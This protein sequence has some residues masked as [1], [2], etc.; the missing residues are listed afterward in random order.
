MQKHGCMTE[1]IISAHPITWMY[2]K[3][4]IQ[5]NIYIC[6]Y[7]YRCVYKQRDVYT[8]TMYIHG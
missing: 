7:I 6:I 3:R 8:C 5:H 4:Y 1:Y 2:D